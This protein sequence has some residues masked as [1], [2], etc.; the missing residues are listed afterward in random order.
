M[1]LLR[2]K[3]GVNYRDDRWAPARD[4][5]EGPGRLVPLTN[6]QLQSRRRL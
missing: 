4:D 1:A 3:D 2:S 6:V 5:L